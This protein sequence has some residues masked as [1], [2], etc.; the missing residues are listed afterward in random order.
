MPRTKGAKDKKP[1]KRRTFVKNSS[2]STSSSTDAG[3][4]KILPGGKRSQGKRG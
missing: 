1:R 2:S 4:R 3:K